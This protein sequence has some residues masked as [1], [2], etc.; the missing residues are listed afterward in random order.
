MISKH[1]EQ[2]VDSHA[3]V[4]IQLPDGSLL[5]QMKRSG[6]K[7]KVPVAHMSQLSHTIPMSIDTVDAYLEAALFHQ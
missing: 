1:K 3:G 6:R 5:P 2:L 7:K 4:E